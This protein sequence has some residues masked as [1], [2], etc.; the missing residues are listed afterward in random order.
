MYMRYTTLTLFVSLAAILLASGCGKDDK[1]PLKCRGCALTSTQAVKYNKETKSAEMKCINCKCD[2]KCKC[3]KEGK[4]DENCKCNTKMK[5]V[6]TSHKCPSCKKT[7]VVTKK[8]DKVKVCGWCGD[9]MEKVRDWFKCPKCKKSVK[10]Q[11]VWPPKVSS[12]LGPVDVDL[13]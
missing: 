9:M 3:N 2:E 1:K 5:K 13:K 6:K 7:D 4:C 8:L 12:G 10:V 11:L